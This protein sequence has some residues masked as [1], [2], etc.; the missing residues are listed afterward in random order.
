MYNK[1]SN[2][3]T[4]SICNNIIYMLVLKVKICDISIKLVTINPIKAIF[5]MFLNL[6]HN[7]GKKKPNGTN[8]VYSNSIN[9]IRNHIQNGITF[10]A[11]SIFR[12]AI[13]GKPTSAKTAVNKTQIPYK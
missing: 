4:N 13:L 8:K 3:S 5:L 2:Y 11:K 6:S 7:I 10:T 9:E 1:I 12:D